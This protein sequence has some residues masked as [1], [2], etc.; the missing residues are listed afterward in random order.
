MSIRSR[1]PISPTPYRK[2][3]DDANICDRWIL[4]LSFLSIILPLYSYNSLNSGVELSQTVLNSL[5]FLQL[6]LLLLLFGIKTKQDDEIEEAYKKKFKIELDSSF[7][8]KL[9]PS[10]VENY[11]D[12]ENMP[13][14]YRKLLAITHENA[15]FTKRNAAMYLNILRVVTFLFIIALVWIIVQG[16]QI[17]E[18]SLSLSGFIVGSLVLERCLASKRLSKECGLITDECIN[19]IQSWDKND[20]PIKV[21]DVYVSYS[22]LLNATKVNIDPGIHRKFM[23]DNNEEWKKVFNRYY[24]KDEEDGQSEY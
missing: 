6:I 4:I 21:I 7:G 20:S 18:F 15:L 3:F 23:K 12:V 2:N 22:T 14:G 10:I 17:N 9:S 19:I 5:F 11:F 1:K 16:Y 13:L 24:S 8:T